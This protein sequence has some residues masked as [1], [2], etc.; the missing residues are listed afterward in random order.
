MSRI[1]IAVVVGLA[2]FFGYVAAVIVLADAVQTMHWAVQAVYFV[3]SGTV[4][5]L[6]ARWLMFWSV[7]QR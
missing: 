5:V 2:G 1:F 6:P 3:V 4:W 7:H